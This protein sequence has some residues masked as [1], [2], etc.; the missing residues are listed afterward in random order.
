[1]VPLR[2]LMVTHQCTPSVG[3]IESFFELLCPR[4][5]A[6]GADVTVA[7]I[8]MSRNTPAPARPYRIVYGPRWND[9]WRLLRWADIVQFSIFDYRWWFAARLLRKRT[10][11]IYHS[12]SRICP[13]MVAWN[14]RETC[15]FATHWRQCPSC[16]HR[17]RSWLTAWTKWLSL[18]IKQRLI[19]RGASAVINISKYAQR[20]FQIPNSRTIVHGIDL[21]RFRPAAESPRET[22]LFAGRLIPEKG[23]H[24]LLEAYARYAAQ[25]GMVRLII[26]G[27]GPQRQELEAMALRLDVA[28]AVEF[29]GALTGQALVERMQRALAVVI[30]SIAPEGFGRTAVEAMACGTPVIA[31]ASGGLQE[32]VGAVGLLYQ[33]LD[34]AALAA[35]LIRMSGDRALQRRL[36]TEGQ[37]YARRHH[38]IER[39]AAQY[40]SLYRELATGCVATE[41]SQRIPGRTSI[42][43]ARGRIISCALRIT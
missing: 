8:Q 21:A 12:H 37:A 26:V 43:E 41:E 14:G 35:H 10:V 29:A 1:M 20:R 22:F 34:A 28:R 23:C 9:M 39:M 18:P 31:A 4:L 7:A 36:Q 2:V 3:G 24:I 17:D 33:P 11:V 25:G 15:S 27:D 38:D 40:L 13:K 42:P 5:S 19:D 6:R 16:L 30:P 32:S